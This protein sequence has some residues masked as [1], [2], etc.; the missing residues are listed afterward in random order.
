[1]RLDCFCKFSL[2]CPIAV[3]LATV[4]I[5]SS[6]AGATGAA[7][8]EERPAESVWSLADLVREAGATHPTVIAKRLE[9]DAALAEVAAARWQRWP[10]PEIEAGRD[11]GGGHSTMLG[12]QQPLW[13]GGRIVAGIAAAEARHD[14][15]G[16]AEAEARREILQRVAEAYVEARRR[17]AQQQIHYRNVQQHERL[18]SMIE[19][20]VRQ[21]ISP[22]VDLELADSRL[23]QAANELSVA[24][25]ALHHSL[26]RLSELTGRQVAVVDGEES[27]ERDLPIDREEALARTLATAPELAVLERQGRA[28]EADIRSERAAWWPMLAL[29]LER[30]E[31]GGLSDERAMLVLRSQLG[32][33]LSTRDQIG[34]ATA[35]REA[36]RREQEAAVRELRAEVAEFWQQLTAARLRLDNSRLH[37]QS[38]ANVFESYTRQYVIGQKTWLD[39]LNAVRE[40]ANAALSVEDAEAEVTWAAL[41]LRLLTG[42]LNPWLDFRAKGGEQ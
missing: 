10:L 18:R 20:R 11:D 28:A 23:Y 27:V 30:R 21:E 39:V 40:A 2:A 9:R 4:L 1:M 3:L 17:Q 16:A 26:T 35:R 37:R 29:R 41:R 7:G 22:G 38:A 42:S 36:L 5:W 24:A 33:G 34:A 25:Q 6:P 14:A 8:S 12:L 32:A 19:R 15:A 31:G 13:S